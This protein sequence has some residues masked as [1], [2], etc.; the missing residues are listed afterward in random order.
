MRPGTGMAVGVGHVRERG[1][2]LEAGVR[3]AYTMNLAV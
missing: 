2:T 1:F 3:V